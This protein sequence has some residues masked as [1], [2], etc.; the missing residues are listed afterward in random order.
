M[1]NRIVAYTDGGAR[2]NPGPAAI[3]IVIRYDGKEKKYGEAIGE[4]TN[5]IAE[6][7]AVIFAL[8]KVKQLVGREEAKN[9]E[10]EVYSD[11]ELVVRHMKGE[12]KVK[13]QVLKDYFVE[14]YNLVQDFGDVSFTHITR[15]E[16]MGADKLVNEALD[17][18]SLL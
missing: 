8:K 4:T 3:G 13:N 1:S 15:D 17:K 18:T 10:V 5:N 9:R 2:G 14:L 16:N 6:Y 12:F 7:Q 11:S